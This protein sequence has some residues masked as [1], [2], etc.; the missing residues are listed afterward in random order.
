MTTKINFLCPSCGIHHIKDRDCSGDWYNTEWGVVLQSFCPKCGKMEPLVSGTRYSR[1]Q[2]R[3]FA[4]RIAM[5]FNLDFDECKQLARK[6]D[7]VDVVSL[8]SNY[9]NLS[10]KLVSL[11]IENGQSKKK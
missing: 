5:N 11:V 7:G 2:V 6:S 10:P 4:V 9:F 3:Y 8:F 1:R